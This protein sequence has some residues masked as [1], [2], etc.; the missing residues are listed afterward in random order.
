MKIIPQ[1]FVLAAATSVSFGAI[2]STD[3]EVPLYPAPDFANGA[4]LHGV[5]GW[6][7]TNGGVGVLDDPLAFVE[8]VEIADG[9]FS[10]F[11]AIGGAYDIPTGANA[12][13][14]RAFSSSLGVTS[15]TMDMG[16]ADSTDD[17]PNRDAFGIT[18]SNGSGNVFSINFTPVVALRQTGDVDAEWEI[19][20]TVGAG[21]T[22]PT[23]L[24]VLADGLYN[25][26]L[27]FTP[28]GTGTN[29]SLGVTG[30][31][32]FD[33]SDDI[34]VSSGTAITDFGFSWDLVDSGAPGDNIFLFDNISAVPEPTSALL[35]CLGGILG[36]ARRKRA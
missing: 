18:L 19:S 11:G 31:N 29:F 3:F 30:K 27:S 7:V 26:A 17:Y 12:T 21:A 8:E 14:S 22:V 10:S 15:F 33:W 9:V 36:V 35:L 16:I 6:T 5:D 28:S 4:T 24:A 32:V 34:A 2:Y 23:G 13:V 25:L 20:Y 1:L